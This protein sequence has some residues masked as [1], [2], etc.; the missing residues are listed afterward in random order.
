MLGPPPFRP[1]QSTILV[2]SR[3]AA[4]KPSV[5]SAA[6]KR[7]LPGHPVR[8]SHGRR[9][10]RPSDRLG[11]PGSRAP[12]RGCGPRA[13]RGSRSP[14]GRSSPSRQLG[15]DL[16][17][18]RLRPLP[19]CCPWPRRAPVIDVG[20]GG[21][22]YVLSGHEVAPAVEPSA[23]NGRNMGR[24]SSR[25]LSS[26]RSSAPNG[27]RRRGAAGTRQQLAAEGVV[28]EGDAHVEPLLGRLDR[29]GNSHGLGSRPRR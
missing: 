16:R 12:R 20:L 21:L 2:S 13:H 25:G 14:S 10:R 3:W 9:R 19:T 26:W 18:W 23:P 7:P 22:H 4:A 8:E 29:R 24:S 1:K 17:G 5:T 27:Y 15:R 11:E 28:A 6:G